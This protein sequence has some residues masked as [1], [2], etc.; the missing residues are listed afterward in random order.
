MAESERAG[1]V[2]EAGEGKSCPCGESRDA[3]GHCSGSWHGCDR[4]D[5]RAE[6]EEEL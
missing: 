5:E 2:A 1:A 3:N 6:P 4:H